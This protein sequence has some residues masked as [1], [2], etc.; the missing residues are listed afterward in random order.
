MS[1]S[2]SVDRTLSSDI[3]SSEFS[4]G[5]Y[6]SIA[7]S[8]S[9]RAAADSSEFSVQN[10]AGH[11]HIFI[12]RPTFLTDTRIEN[13]AIAEIEHLRQRFRQMI[14]E[15]N[16]P[17]STPNPS[18]LL[19]A[20]GSRDDPVRKMAA[21]KLQSLINDP[22]FAE[23]FVSSGGLPKLRLL[24]LESSGNTLAYGLASFARLL[25]VDQ[26]WEA[27]DNAVVEKVMEL[28]VCQP[29]VNI[30]RGAM[31]ILVAVVSRPYNEEQNGESDHSKKQVGGFA[32]LKPALATYPQFLE[33]LVSR[34][35]SAD[36]ALCANALQLIN[37]L[38]RDAITN[39]AETE[40]PKFIKRI[41]DLGVIKA[42]Y[43]LMKG[44]ALQDLSHPLLEF[45]ALTK[46]LL[47]RWRDVPVDL[48]KPEHRRTIKAIH[49]SSNPEKSKPSDAGSGEEEPRK[50]HHPFKWRRLGFTS[51][52][53]ENDFEAT[54]F[55]G[56]MDLS[57]WIR[58]S[59]EEFQHYL[60]EQA[61]A[62]EDSRAPLAQVSLTMTQV[63]F[64]HFE[65]DRNE[66][67]ESKN[68][69]ALESRSQ[70][71]EKIFKPLLLHWSRLHVAGL[72]AFLRLWKAAGANTGDFT[73]IADL[74]RILIESVVG[75]AD[76]SKS[77]EE[78]EKEMAATDLKSLRQLQMEIM[79]L[80]FDD[81]WGHHLQPSKDELL[82]EATQL[83]CE[84]RIRCMLAGQWF[85]IDLEYPDHENGGPVQQDNLHA[86]STY[87]RFI[88]LAAD[89]RYLHWGDFEAREDPWPT[90][91]QLSDKVDTTI[92]TSV[93]SG[94]G[95]VGDDNSD[96]DGATKEG[97]IN[98]VLINGILPS[99]RG[100]DSGHARNVSKV[101]KTSKHSNRQTERETVL[102][103]FMPTSKQVASEWVDGLLFVL[104]QQAIT[105]PTNKYIN[106]IADM[107]LKTRLL[108]LR[109]N[110]EDGMIGGMQGTEMPEI[111][112][113]EGLDE[114]YYYQI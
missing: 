73:K 40:W 36:H 81:I 21:F 25:D 91:D 90:V 56:L 45:Q 64:E 69:L 86:H 3:T 99:S 97:T 106:L 60:L 49:L 109:Y 9:I 63:L 71:N 84:Q 33:M 107:A 59:Q 43:L 77:I 14:M 82:N 67:E 61:L 112:S 51:E 1:D 114:N 62:P 15:G 100:K 54:G 58:R 6:T 22:S 55:L 23:M 96:D 93:T 4:F 108:N 29:L 7:S 110:E 102:L 89:R 27:V 113:R 79:D 35:S 75:G 74:V 111:P 94:I 11:A 52:Q 50:G 80:Q 8:T 26:G 16:S 47:R 44:T 39:D 28:V 95:E 38:M 104:S 66:E 98:R 24:V 101:S 42:V 78:I 105:A 48:Q 19:K 88:R 12:E 103:S 85:P 30:L 46:I 92:I 53:P 20:L 13:P 31:A 83:L 57:D 5:D 72:Y 2:N 34:L 65:V 18:D 10:D 41:Q 32:A 68:Y 37:S 76:R 17:A 87:W 70:N